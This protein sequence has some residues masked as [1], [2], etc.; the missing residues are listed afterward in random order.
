MADIISIDPVEK[1]PIINFFKKTWRTLLALDKSTRLMIITITLIILSTPFII[2]N[3]QAFTSS[4]QV[5]TTP[6][7]ATSLTTGSYN[8]PSGQTAS[9][10]ITTTQSVTIGANKLAL[11]WV[12]QGNGT[13]GPASIS[14]PNRTWTQ[15]TTNT[16]GLRR[17][18]LYRSMNFVDTTGAITITS[19]APTNSTDRANEIVWSLVEYGNVDISGTNGSGAVAQ[20]GSRNYQNAGGS[21]TLSG[22]I[23][24]SL[25]G[26]VG[27]AVVG[28]FA[29][30]SPSSSVFPGT[31]YTL[32][33]GFRCVT[34]CG[35]AEFRDNF[36]Q[37]VDMSWSSSSNWMVIAAEL[38]A[39]SG[40][41]SITP[42]PTP[43]P[44][45]TLTPTPTPI[46]N[47]TP[48]PTFI[49]TPSPTPIQGTITFSPV[50]FPENPIIRPN[51]LPGTDG[52]N[53]NGPSLIKVPDWIT[54][55][56]GSYYLYFSHHSGKYIRLAYSNSLHGPWTVYTPGTLNVSQATVCGSHIASPDVHVDNVRQEIRMYFHCPISGGI[57][58]Y[59]FVATSSDGI[60]FAHQTQRLGAPYFRVFEYGGYYYSIGKGGSS[61]ILYRSTNPYSGFVKGNSIL[62]SSR[63]TAVFLNGNTAYIFYSRIGDAPERI[64]LSTMDISG[65]WSTWTPSAPIEILR[66]EFDYEGA[67][68]PISPSKGGK[69]GGPVNQLRDPG[70]YEEADKLYLLYSVAGEQGIGA[71]ELLKQ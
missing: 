27:S 71:A 63:H 21:R 12:V 59:T 36:S 30:G 41:G 61:S 18:T 5:A 38:K 15:I 28:G 33:G 40:G 69:A 16:P 66:P 65:D 60:N 47:L 62:P 67:N 43:I 64:L 11:I 54:N 17:L 20:F 53:I 8:P 6:I 1:S 24:L 70:I 19:L 42:T 10:A 44:A 48:T 31:G 55:K 57:T 14:D 29:M 23:T 32:T 25:S 22:S 68:L 13:A 52:S 35:Q 4:A 34:A 58:Q 51:M 26:N 7:I 56:L 9:T 50:R 39:A 3:R 49:P 45:P 2:V 46:S 37:L